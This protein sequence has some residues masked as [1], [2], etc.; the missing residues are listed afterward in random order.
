[1]QGRYKAIIC[2]QDEYLLE[3]IRY[4]HLNPVRAKIA[5]TPE[6]YAFSGHRS[7]L[8]GKATEA[9]DPRPVLKLF[10]G[11]KSYRRFVTDAIGHGHKEEYYEVEDQRFLGGKE[12]GEKVRAET[13][14]E[15][16]GRIKRVALNKAVEELA[17]RLEANPAELRK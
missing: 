9:M 8:E 2:A 17:K 1:F 10:G 13:E 11:P 4:I 15:S 14:G 12:F 16:E 7:Y 5:R 3:L 6:Q